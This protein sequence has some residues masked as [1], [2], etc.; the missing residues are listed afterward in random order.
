M[1]AHAFLMIAALAG[2]SACGPDATDKQPSEPVQAGPEI[3]SGKPLYDQAGSMAPDVTLTRENGG[4]ASITA[5]RGTP[6]LVN[7]WATWCAPCI[8]EL[9]A[10]DRLAKAQGYDM[11]V[12]AVSQDM[13]GWDK[14]T[15]FLRE[16]PLES[17]TVLADADG[18]LSR[19]LGVAGLP[20]TILYDAEGRELWRVN[21][22]REWDEPGGLPPETAA[23][24]KS[25]AN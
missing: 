18:A 17:L 14:I 15:P 16:N 23:P 3:V 8:A 20:V 12:I 13:Q 6:T 25:E 1:R 4:P 22:P 24:E 9:P 19:A 11:N 5:F 10:L 21:G 2:T 7:L